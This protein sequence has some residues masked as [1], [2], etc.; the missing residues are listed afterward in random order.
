MP[1]ATQSRSTGHCLDRRRRFI[2]T[3]TSSSREA[4]D[5]E[6][7]GLPPIRVPCPEHMLL[8]IVLQN[9]QES[10]SRLSRLVDIA[11][12]VE[13]AAELNWE[14]VIATARRGNMESATALSCQLARRILESP[15]PAEVVQKMA[16]PPVSRF[17]LAAMRPARFAVHQLGRGRFVPALLLEFWLLRGAKHRLFLLSNCAHPVR[18]VKLLVFQFLVYATALISCATPARRTRLRFWLSTTTAIKEPSG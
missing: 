1:T 18:L 12:I 9:L 5:V 14:F 7:P 10:F 4:L 6:R 16:P 15:I 3:R 13:A 2:W 8:H 11:A 17:H